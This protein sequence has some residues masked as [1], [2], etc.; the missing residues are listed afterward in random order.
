MQNG[1]N[2]IKS[3]GA[4]RKCSGMG[5][6]RQVRCEHDIQRREV[7]MNHTTAGLDDELV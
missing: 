7:I 3:N 5:F 2:H 4:K 6:G 1:T